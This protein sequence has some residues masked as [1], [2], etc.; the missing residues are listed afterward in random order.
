MEPMIVMSIDNVHVFALQC[1]GCA[2]QVALE[3]TQLRRADPNFRDEIEGHWYAQSWK[4]SPP[5][6]L[7]VETSRAGEGF[8]KLSFCPD[9][10]SAAEQKVAALSTR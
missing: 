6:W 5:G 2:K 1:S 9:C 3:P 4:G 7:I 10:A 8:K